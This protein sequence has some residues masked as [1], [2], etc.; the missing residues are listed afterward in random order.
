MAKLVTR[1][2]DPTAGR[3]LIDGYDIKHV[4]RGG[5]RPRAECCREQGECENR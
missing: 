4:T 1:F 3:V 5:I 2:Y